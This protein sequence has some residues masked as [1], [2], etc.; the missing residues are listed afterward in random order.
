MV[1]SS[2]E[3]AAGTSTR[4]AH[5]DGSPSKGDAKN[6]MALDRERLAKKFCTS[7]LE[8][9]TTDQDL[10]TFVEKCK[11][12][13]HFLTGI[14]V[15]LHQIELARRLLS[16][17]D[18]GVI[19]P[20]AYPLGGLPVELKVAQAE[21][22]MKLGAQQIDVCLPIEAVKGEKLEVVRQD[23]DAIIGS[24]GA[25]VD[26]IAF[27]P[28]TAY[29]TDDEKR[30]C[31]EIIKDAGGKVYKTNA[32]FGLETSPA[33]ISLLRDEFSDTLEIVATGNVYSLETTDA[34]LRA[35]ADKIGTSMPFQIF[36]SLNSLLH[37]LC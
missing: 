28:N 14:A 30:A 24:L 27:I 19:A 34:L 35:G 15:H 3:P 23:V 32:G 21:Y 2:V 11:S 22:A 20:I 7:L 31:Y 16:D 36:E 18:I 33:E 8:P 9:A 13:V 26:R 5:P 1:K 37:L 17:C 10:H 25:K 29:L 12:H 6:T 4:P